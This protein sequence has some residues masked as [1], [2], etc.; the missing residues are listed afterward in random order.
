MHVRVCVECGEE[1]R[2]DIVACA[3]CGGQL[4]DRHED[5]DRTVVA[6]PAGSAPGPDAAFTETVSQ[7]KAATDLTADADSLIEAGLEVRVRP[8]PEGGY[9]LLVTAPDLERALSILGLLAEEGAPSAEGTA[10]SC[11][12]CGVAVRPGVVECPECGLGL[13]DAPE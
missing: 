3:D 6:Q 5:G 11:P 4:E 9:R 8:V 12:A 10:Q 1:Y 13:G 7:A 2:P